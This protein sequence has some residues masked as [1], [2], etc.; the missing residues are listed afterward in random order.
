MKPQNLRQS[1][2]KD[3]FTRSGHGFGFTSEKV[4]KALRS[5]TGE[6]FS[7]HSLF[8]PFQR[9]D[10]SPV[11]KSQTASAPFLGACSTPGSPQLLPVQAASGYLKQ[12]SG[13]EISANLIPLTSPIEGGFY[14]PRITE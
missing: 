2:A 5:V 10:S 9:G 8:S 12:L 7:P 14:E 13:R 1:L 11:Q 3:R 4:I 6:G